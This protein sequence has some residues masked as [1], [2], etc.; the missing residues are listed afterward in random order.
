MA[1]AKTGKTSHT[2]HTETE[3]AAGRGG[4]EAKLSLMEQEGLLE[5]LDAHAKAVALAVGEVLIEKLAKAQSRPTEDRHTEHRGSRE[6]I[7]REHE[8]SEEAWLAK[9]PP[10]DRE[11]FKK[12]DRELRRLEET[13]EGPERLLD[14]EQDNNRPPV[15]HEGTWQ[16]PEY[17][18]VPP[19]PR[20]RKLDGLS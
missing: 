5:L 1:D 16:L 8:R 11:H 12:T 10:G 6:E 19:D 20:H 17:K 4:E 15:K 3:H 9:Y 2:G 18:P 13:L 7:E 14:R